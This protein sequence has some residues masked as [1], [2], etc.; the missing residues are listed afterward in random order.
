MERKCWLFPKTFFHVLN[1]VF[2]CNSYSATN[3]RYKIAKLQKYENPTA[4]LEN[5]WLLCVSA[6][7]D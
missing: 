7:R 4:N 6:Q 3:C 2:G 1:Q 5:H